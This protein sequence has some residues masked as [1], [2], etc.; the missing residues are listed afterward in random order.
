MSRARLPLLPVQGLMEIICTMYDI[1]WCTPLYSM[2]A[3]LPRPLRHG[4]CYGFFFIYT[5]AMPRLALVRAATR[6][7]GVSLPG[8]TDRD[9]RLS[10]RAVR[11]PGRWD[12]DLVLGRGVQRA[13]S[14]KSGR[15]TDRWGG[16]SGLI[17]AL[18]CLLADMM[19]SDGLCSQLSERFLVGEVERSWWRAGR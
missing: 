12:L 8:A 1:I 4:S 16:E 11:F 19:I 9:P 18:D 6:T 13:L 2:F 10:L 17:L 3:L 15:P 5:Y 7:P 14:D